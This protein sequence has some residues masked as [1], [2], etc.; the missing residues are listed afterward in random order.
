MKVETIDKV[1]TEPLRRLYH[2]T[3]AHVPY[4]YA[5]SSDEFRRGLL[6]PSDSLCDQ[7]IV[8]EQ[9]GSDIAAYADTAIWLDGDDRWGVIRALCYE[10]GDRAKAQSVL[11][12]AENHLFS[13]GV[14]RIYAFTHSY[15]FSRFGFTALSEIAGHV[16]GLMGANE[17]EII[18]GWRFLHLPNYE[19][20]EPVASD[21]DLEIEVR[22]SEGL[23]EGPDVLLNLRQAGKQVG[24][25]KVKS[26]GHG[27]EATVRDTFYIDFMGIEEDRRGR[28][29]GRYLL[30][31]T[32]WEMNQR[33]YKTATL[34][35]NQGN[36][37]A[38]LLYTNLGFRVVD[39]S[40]K[41]RKTKG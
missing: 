12:E 9:K 31:A 40:Y 18:G 32:L 11:Q 23:G 3:F 41:F 24:E 5:V 35:T 10:T 30:Q 37:R 1:D 29:L 38:Q 20:S 27:Q 14:T 17:Y 28:G 8:S 6:G 13:K 21:R 16:C 25:V 4:V 39:T 36:H 22:E 34:H 19:M 33:G 15:S 2:A 26:T 7:K